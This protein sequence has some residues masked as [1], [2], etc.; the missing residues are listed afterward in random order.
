MKRELTFLNNSFDTVN[1]AL[2]NEISDPIVFDLSR[3]IEWFEN[4]H[5]DRKMIYSFLS[6]L[7]ECDVVYLIIWESVSMA[8]HFAKHLFKCASMAD[9]INKVL[10][11]AI[12]YHPHDALS[13]MDIQLVF[14]FAQTLF[15]KHRQRSDI[16]MT[17]PIKG[18]NH[19]YY[20]YI[21]ID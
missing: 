3:R 12:E 4:S 17:V 1:K 7:E 2:T 13:D 5:A 21:K 20:F 19:C 9:P 16:L 15:L 8:K 6:T 10:A 11:A 18:E 14:L